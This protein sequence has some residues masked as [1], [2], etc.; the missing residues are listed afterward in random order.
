LYDLL[1]KMNSLQKAWIEVQ[2]EVLSHQ[3]QWAFGSKLKKLTISGR[4]LNTILPDAFL[5]KLTLRTTLISRRLTPTVSRSFAGLYHTSDFTLRITDTNLTRLPN[6]LLRYF[7]ET[8][9][10]TLD[11]R[12]NQLVELSENVLNMTLK[13]KHVEKQMNPLQPTGKPSSS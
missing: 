2:E 1:A 12:H 10:V 9:H 13:E 6:G 5:G 3:I 11:F 4:S 8:W 7:A